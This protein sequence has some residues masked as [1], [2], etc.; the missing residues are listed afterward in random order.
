MFATPEIIER[1]RQYFQA[2]VAPDHEELLAVVRRYT[3]EKVEPWRREHPR[4]TTRFTDVVAHARA[5]DIDTALGA[6]A[7]PGKEALPWIARVAVI[8]E[9]GKSDIDVALAATAGLAPAWACIALSAWL[10]A[11]I[12]SDR[13]CLIWA[14]GGSEGRI[15][16]DCVLGPVWAAGEATAAILLQRGADGWSAGV[17]DAMALRGCLMTAGY[18]GLEFAG[19]RR[20]A[21]EHRFERLIDQ[22]GSPLLADAVKRVLIATLLCHSAILCGA[23]RDAVAASFDYA[24]NR[25][26]FGKP[27]L[28]HQ[29]IAARLAEMLTL[30]DVCRLTLDRAADAQ[31]RKALDDASLGCLLGH[32][33][34][35]VHAV[36]RDAIQVHGG[37][38]YVE[39]MRLAKSY[40]DARLLTAWLTQLGGLLGNRRK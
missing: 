1:D 37:H 40:R 27:I 18:T 2:A 4:N 12:H 19:A 15:D 10:P 7:D 38:G 36:T 31:A 30:S 26:S 24:R 13:L 32:I 20:W 28:Q 35:A 33:E 29:L 25:Q 34:E 9:L 22:R 3:R 6:V 17:A 8:E 21:G 23:L 11:S 16:E 39:Q 14:D 5:L